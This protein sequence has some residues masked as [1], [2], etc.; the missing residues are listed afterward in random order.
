MDY[1]IRKATLEDIPFITKTIMEA[2]K[3][4]TEN[5][6]L[7]KFFELDEAT[8]YKLMVQILEEEIDGCEFSLSSFM[9]VTYDGEV[10]AA[11]GGW[12][13]GVE[14]GMSSGILKSNLIGYFFPKDKIAKTRGKSDIIKDIQI[15]R[16]MGTYQLEYSFV[17]EKHRGQRL[18]NKLMVE[19]LKFAKETYPDVKKAQLHVFENNPVIIKVHERSGYR[20]KQRHES[21]HSDILQYMPGNV[22]LLMEKEIDN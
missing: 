2:E 18:V 7:A 20:I 16:E 5:L 12:L 9:V 8:I 1:E 17:D 3:S 21:N 19:H 22:K 11:M 10:V 13:E 6:G 15:E 4:M 14:D